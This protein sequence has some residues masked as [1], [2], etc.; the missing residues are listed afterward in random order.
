MTSNADAKTTSGSADDQ[1]SGSDACGKSLFQEKLAELN[2]KRVEAYVRD[3]SAK[4]KISKSTEDKRNYRAQRKAEGIAQYL[5]EVPEDENA[6]RTVY[7]VAKAI[8]ADKGN[9]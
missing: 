5:V 7:A 2:L 9:G 4:K 1:G 8:V 3:T 6:K